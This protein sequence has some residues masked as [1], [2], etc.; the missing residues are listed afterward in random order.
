MIANS[1]KGLV[2]IAIPAYKDKWLAE[3]IESALNQDYENLELLIVDD[4]SPFGLEKIVSP[5]LK[6]KRVYYYYNEKNLGEESIVLNWNRCIDLANGEYFVLLCDDDILRPNFVST[7]LSLAKKYPDCNVFKSRTRLINSITN[8]HIND[9]PIWPEFESFHLFL[10]ETINGKRHH[11][12]TEFLLRT[13][14]I[15]KVGGYIIHPAG[16]YSD[17]ASILLFSRYGGISSIDECLV[18]FRKSEQ[19]ISSRN[20]FNVEKV[21]SALQYYKWLNDEFSISKEQAIKLSERRDF[22]LYEYF[23]NSSFL[24]A[25]RILLLVPNDIWNLKKKIICFLKYLKPKCE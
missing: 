18:V 24:N 25:F 8:T 21:K 10:E 4:H 22:E 23:I 3:A 5:Y 13:A 11:T 15:K 17:I 1:N 9:T 7:L 14:Y 12:I 16:Y 6:D 19:N 20:D 2:T